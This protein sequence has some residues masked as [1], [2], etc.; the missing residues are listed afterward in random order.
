VVIGPD[1]REIGA[2][3]IG[4]SSDDTSVANLVMRV[5]VDLLPVTES[6]LILEGSEEE[7]PR[8]QHDRSYKKAGFRDL[9]LAD[10]L[11]GEFSPFSKLFL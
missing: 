8:R 1:R 4:H 2:W 6:G 11:G 7:R 10:S 9:T 5:N 3:V